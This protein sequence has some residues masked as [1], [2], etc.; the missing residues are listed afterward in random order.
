MTSTFTARG[1]R[2]SL[3][4]L[5]LAL[6]MLGGG[7][8]VLPASAAPDAPPT[9]VRPVAIEVSSG[10]SG[11]SNLDDG[12]T[13]GPTWASNQTSHA[14]G[15]DAEPW[16]RYELPTPTALT[17]AKIWW[18]GAYA[19]KYLLVGWDGTEWLPLATATPSAPEQPAT[20]TNLR[21]TDRTF[22]YVGLAVA[23]IF[24]KDWGT[25]IH[26]LQLFGTPT[27]DAP[28]TAPT[29]D[30]QHYR[31]KPA[32]PAGATDLALGGKATASS[33]NGGAPA[34]AAIDGDPTTRWQAALDDTPE[35]LTIDLLGTADIDVLHVVPEA[36]YAAEYLVETSVRGWGDWTRFAHVNGGSTSP[37]IIMPDEDVTAPVTARYVRL[38]VLRRGMPYGASFW[39]VSVY[40]DAATY[41]VAPPPAG[42]GKNG[43]ILLSYGKPVVTHSSEE[44]YPAEHLTDGSLATRW[45][46]DP[47]AS[48]RDPAWDHRAWA[49]VD[50]GATPESLTQVSMRWQDAAAT[51]YRLAVADG[52][53]APGIDD[54]AWTTI[55]ETTAGPGKRDTVNLPTGTTVG[56][57][58]LVDMRVP[59]V[60]G[61]GNRYGYSMWELR[62]YGD[63]GTGFP[64]VTP[65]ANPAGDATNPDFDNL[66]L[67]WSDE[68]DSAAGTPA[69]RT[70]W[71]LDPAPVGQ[72]NAE[73]QSYTE[74]TDNIAHDGAG[75]LV[76]TAVKGAD[77]KYTSGRLNTSN[78]M[79]AQYGRYAARVK[80][81][82]G[83]GLWP[84]F[85][86]MGSD[87]LDGTPWPTNG[88]ID[89]MEVLGHD[90]KTT[91]T[92]IHGPMYSGMGG[93]G[94]SHT[95]TVDLSQDFHT[96][97][98]DWDRTGMSFWLD[99][100]SNVLFRIDRSLI[101]DERGQAWVYDQPFFLILNLAVGGDWPGS[102]DKNTAF[103][104]QMK[105]DWVR[106]WQSEGSGQLLANF[107]IPPDPN[108]KDEATVTVTAPSTQAGTATTVDVRVT[109]ARGIADGWATVTAGTT[110]QTV[111]IV[112]GTGRATLP[113]RE[114]G[115]TTVTAS[116]AGDARTLPASGSAT[117][118]VTRT[119]ATMS[120]ATSTSVKVAAGSRTAVVR[121]RTA[122]GYP[123]TGTVRLKVGSR[124]VESKK[125]SAWHGG[126]ATF[127]VPA[128]TARGSR[129]VTAEYLG[130]T[131]VSA[132]TAKVVVTSSRARPSV[133]V[134]VHG[135]TQKIGR[136]PG[137]AVV[138][139]HASGVTTRAT[140]TVKIKVGK[141]TTKV[142]LTSRSRGT[143]VVRLPK[144]TRAGKLKVTVTYS[145]DAA[146]TGRTVSGGT[147][148]VRR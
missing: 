39:T 77:G 4:S 68:F 54:A 113:G 106:V 108:A 47:G 114:A 147:V 29:T 148:K 28:G 125:L 53:T 48:W 134:S 27:T 139:V 63:A 102:P 80:V 141:R 60:V 58:L 143:V 56:R 86:M 81:P 83:K 101:E 105:V 90:T 24:Q 136:T 16:I 140:G 112:D 133:K 51:S 12:S 119:T 78:R 37:T 2:R 98:V 122:S 36:S 99:D 109:S 26:E 115:A 50:L 69:D 127:T 88:E 20:L 32:I 35:Q 13:N 76:I 135:R 9:H 124:V 72:N 62:A 5:S 126:V 34:S 97:G 6:A 71:H 104:A 57:Y 45:A 95:G 65:P 142:K 74:S 131:S 8:A 52:A 110:T 1:R 66:K 42:E 11:K 146:H 3:T 93:I 23:S 121:I 85:W 30:P 73:L 92:T 130:D 38:T 132:A 19:T 41:E 21:H 117:W 145:G 64:L 59:A 14:D 49:V 103:P 84:A 22:T 67:V 137:Y 15:L 40:G 7:L 79:H 129:T 111:R 31:G 33:A 96:Y 10:A 138:R 128:A 44:G 94:K 120:V 46:V 118:T 61:D 107:P 17:E 116:F 100:A 70:R 91:H 123:A 82:T 89:V 75:N 25:K 18:E 144:Q 55:Y 87:F 43:G